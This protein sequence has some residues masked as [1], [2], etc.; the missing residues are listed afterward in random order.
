MERVF[1]SASRQSV[2]RADGELHSSKISFWGIPEVWVRF[3][4]AIGGL[5]L[6]FAA[7]IFSSVSRQA[8]NLWGTV[9]LATVALLLATLVGL[10][11]V[12]YLTR[13]I[14]IVRVRNAFEFEVTRVG[15]AYFLAV[16][17]I[18]VAALNTGNNLLY[19]VVAAMLAAILVSGVVSARALSGL[20]LD[21]RLP[22]HIFAG[23]AAP[24]RIVL[25]NRRR[26]L[27][28]CSVSVLAT[29]EKKEKRWRWMPSTFGFPPRRAPEKQ[30][31]RFADR[32]FS[33][34]QISEGKQEEILAGA[35]Y[36][37]YLAA[38]SAQGADLNF[39]F[40][41]RGQFQQRGFR[42]STRFPFAFLEKTRGIPSE[43][44]IVI[45]PSVRAA[46]SLAAIFPKINGE[47]ESFLRG[48]GA[49]L[50]SIREGT[51][52]D[53]SRHVD[54]KATA[55]SGS[56]KVRE[57]NRDDDRRLRIVFDNPACGVLSAPAYESM[58][59][60]AASLSWYFAQRRVQ[61]SFA[62]PDY[63]GNPDLYA[64]L[65]YLALVGPRNVDMQG[66]ENDQSQ[67]ILN[68]LP[69][70]PS[71]NVVVTTLESAKVP[72]EIFSCSHL[73]F[74]SEAPR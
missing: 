38:G 42:L 61:L 12:P 4:L 5:A 25:R 11:T 3:L 50:H 37:P 14:E 71:Y 44:E 51:A 9:I 49:E 48:E 70:S 16:L 64:F 63:D 58:V 1:Q 69:K 20:E 62:A 39:S 45:Y 21:V 56:M 59:Q 57:F 24:G 6:A 8:G 52:G 13:R 29:K 55:K 67:S 10:T 66:P 33:R 31:I 47:F 23:D 54:W 2:H 28:S 36:F 74:Q 30:W 26:H 40:A 34:V 65:K 35:V 18:G 53:S 73:I 68:N 19:I 15:I 17:V 46:G 22:R 27:P 32:K 60:T 72:R 43:S 41:Q 7:A